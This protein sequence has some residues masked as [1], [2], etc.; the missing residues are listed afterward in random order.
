MSEL[1]EKLLAK[2]HPDWV[3]ETIYHPDP[4]P[5]PDPDPGHKGKECYAVEVRATTIRKGRFL[6]G[7]DTISGCWYYPDARDPEVDGYYPDMLGR[8][9]EALRGKLR[10]AGEAI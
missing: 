6:S 9:I 5:G 4:Y 10:E 8:A 7:S 3:I 1:L 2:E